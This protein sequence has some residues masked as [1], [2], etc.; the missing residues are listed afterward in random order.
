[1][2]GNPIVVRMIQSTIDKTIGDLMDSP[3]KG[4]QSLVDLGN[5]FSTNKMHKELA[6]TLEI[7][8]NSPSS[9]YLL[10]LRALAQNVDQQTL[11]SFILNTAY[12]SWSYGAKRVKQYK[13]VYKY[14]IPW[15]ILF[16]FTSKSDPSL[17]NDKITQIIEQ[18]KKLGI[19]TYMFFTDDIGSISHIL[20]QNSDCAFILNLPPSSITPGI[21]GK[22]KSYHHTF[23][24]VLYDPFADIKIFQDATK[25]LYG[26]KCLFGTH[27]YY[28]DAYIEPILKGNWMDQVLASN[29]PFGFL[30]ESPDCS[31]KNAKLIQAYIENSR[32]KPD[33]PVF[34]MD[35]YGDT[36]KISSQISGASCVFKIMGNGDVS[37]DE[38]GGGEGFNI[39]NTSLIKILAKVL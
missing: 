27:S 25:L 13:K 10:S 15:T 12:N 35:L 31:P 36:R 9:P 29:S 16:D 4:A 26:H 22:I 39:K 7:M 24:S 18:G 37:C 21:M 11:K 32:V 38:L 6:N 23:F 30:I 34:L 5:R 33:H 2:V 20:R 19:Y 17:S 14:H 3:Q 28:S 8:L 1:M